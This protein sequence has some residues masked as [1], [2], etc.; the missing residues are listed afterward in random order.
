MSKFL[1]SGLRRDIVIAVSG[2]D[3]PRAT[4]VKRTLEDHY[5]ERVAR[6]EFHSALE[7]LVDAGFLERRVDEIHD[8]YS[9][10]DAGSER[11]EEHVDWIEENVEP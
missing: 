11:L 8:R 2:L 7:A 9:L 5:D 3:G 10:T 1:A 6:R 4:A